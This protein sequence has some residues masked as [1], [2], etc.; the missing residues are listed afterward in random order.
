MSLGG[1]PPATDAFIGAKLANSV[2]NVSSAAGSPPPGAAVSCRV[3]AR[4]PAMHQSYST[5][6]VHPRESQSYWRDVVGR[7][8]FPLALAF[9]R[10][11]GFH[12][13]LTVW[14]FGELSLSH[15]A[16]EPLCYRRQRQHLVSRDEESLLVTIPDA[17]AVSFSQRGHSVNCPPGGFILERSDE[18]YEFSYA[19][20]NALWV[21][22]VPEQA[23]RQ[24]IGTIDRYCACGLEANAGGGALLTG[25]VRLLAQNLAQ[26]GERERQMLGRQ[27]LDLLALA[28][29]SNGERLPT[30]NETAV[31]AAHLQRC[32]QYIRQ[33]LKDA[34]LSPQQIAAACGISPR[35]LHSLFRV[36]GRTV[37]QWLREQRLQA[38]H[39]SLTGAVVVKS[40]AQIAYEW[41]FSDQAHFCRVFKE[42]FGCSPSQLRARASA[43]RQGG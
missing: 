33:H 21:V 15:L 10:Q 27:V 14:S 32:Q 13:Q 7:N 17:Q 3:A 24:R 8:Y 30:S 4:R 43:A 6:M 23:L 5:A 16:S 26:A 12:G 28:L 34:T 20:N 1:R 18:P 40:I 25:Y 31:Q 22:K 37:S 42:H 11:E 38:C 41:G 9:G 39:D 35:Y 29:E 2:I 19:R 36:T